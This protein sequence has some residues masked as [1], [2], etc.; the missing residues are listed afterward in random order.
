MQFHFHVILCCFVIIYFYSS[1]G[2][3]SH[4]LHVS[5]LRFSHLHV[6]ELCVLLAS[7][8]TLWLYKRFP[9][10]RSDD[11]YSN[12]KLCPVGQFYVTHCSV[13]VEG[14]QCSPVSNFLEKYR[15]MAQAIPQKMLLMKTCKKCFTDP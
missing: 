7:S 1:Y 11:L 8:S 15:P 10:S 6:K 13:C 5:K 9:K 3:R 12:F 2:Y 14:I 4:A